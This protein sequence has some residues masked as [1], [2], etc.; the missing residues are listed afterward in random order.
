M[1]YSSSAPEIQK[2]TWVYEQFVPNS[3]ARQ[4]ACLLKRAL[5]MKVECM[6]RSLPL[7]VL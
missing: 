4:L 5:A 7:P 1:F 6:T 3:T 2:Q